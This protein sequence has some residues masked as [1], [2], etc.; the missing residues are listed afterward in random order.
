MADILGG[1]SLG[2]QSIREGEKTF[3][4]KQS[5]LQCCLSKHKRKSCAG[6]DVATL[7]Y[8]LKQIRLAFC[9]IRAAGQ[10]AIKSPEL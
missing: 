9:T 6:V 8:E 4:I 10:R 7:S 3:A 1:K 2:N 5:V